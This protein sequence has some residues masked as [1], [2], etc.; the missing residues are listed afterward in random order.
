MGVI[1]EYAEARINEVRGEVQKFLTKPIDY[2]LS[3]QIL[4]KALL[5]EWLDYIRPVKGTK[6]EHR[7]EERRL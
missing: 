2:V 6:W 3:E 7:I 4:R 1:L 5:L